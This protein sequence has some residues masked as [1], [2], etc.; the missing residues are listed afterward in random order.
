[1]EITKFHRAAKIRAQ[2]GPAP[3]SR[4]QV[5][6]GNKTGINLHER[7]GNNGRETGVHRRERKQRNTLSLS[8]SL[9]F[10]RCTIGIRIFS[11]VRSRNI[12]SPRRNENGYRSPHPPPL[13]FRSTP[14]PWR[15]RPSRSNAILS[16]RS[17]RRRATIQFPP[18]F[19]F[20]FPSPTLPRVPFHPVP[21][22]TS[23][24]AGLSHLF[25]HLVLG[26]EQHVPSLEQGDKFETG[27]ANF[28]Y[29]SYVRLFGLKFS[30]STSAF[31]K[32]R[33]IFFLRKLVRW[34]ILLLAF[35][36]TFER[37]YSIFLSSLF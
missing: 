30:V 15:V 32:M 12:H 36:R 16:R 20:P 6:R 26:R 5:C 23:R 9:R 8:L 31:I 37:I 10:Q 13:V 1:M 28:F 4:K 33:F 2:R 24:K 19:P 11:A 29:V 27:E 22:K 21:S 14:T 34:L 18:S 35:W 7:V 3:Y 17:F 25:C